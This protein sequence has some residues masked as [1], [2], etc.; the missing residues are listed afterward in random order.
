MVFKLN[1]FFV[2][3]DSKF[4]KELEKC[5]DAPEKLASCFLNSVSLARFLGCFKHDTATRCCLCTLYNM[6]AIRFWPLILIL[7]RYQLLI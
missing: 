5:E 3:L 6:F 4:V 1:V 7:I 2:F